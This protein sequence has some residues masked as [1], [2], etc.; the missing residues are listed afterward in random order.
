M[1]LRF[2][3]THCGRALV[4]WC[5]LLAAALVASAQFPAFDGPPAGMDPQREAPYIDAESILA[6]A[7]E[8]GEPNDVDFG[9]QVGAQY[10]APYDYTKEQGLPFIMQ[11]E[12]GAYQPG[13][14]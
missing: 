14:F 5:V 4:A 12:G 2:V 3:R 6:T 7:G 13:S 9:P 8:G 11:Q 1:A 10:G